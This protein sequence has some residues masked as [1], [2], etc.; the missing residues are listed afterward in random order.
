MDPDQENTLYLNQI[1]QKAADHI[2]GPGELGLVMARAGV[3]KTSF[4]ARLALSELACGREVLHIALGQNLEQVNAHYQYLYRKW[5]TLKEPTKEPTDVLDNFDNL[6]RHRAIQ[7]YSNKVLTTDQ[8]ENAIDVFSKHL[9]LHPNVIVVDG[10]DWSS[11]AEKD[12]QGLKNTAKQTGA[13]LWM[14]ARTDQDCT[15]SGSQCLK[16]TAGDAYS[17]VELALCM[18]PKGREVEVVVVR[19]DD[20]EVFRLD[21]DS[22]LPG[23]ADSEPAAIKA[24]PSE[25]VLHSG[26]AKGT[27]AEF[28]ACAEKWGLVEKNFSYKGREVVRSRGLVLLSAQELKQGAVS[29]AYLQAHL[30]REFSKDPDFKK[31]LQS[32]WH[33]VNQASE[34]FSVGVINSDGTVKGGTGWAVELA[35]HQKKQVHVYD[36]EKKSWYLWENKQWEKVEKPVISCNCFAGT[37]TRNLNSDGKKA[38]QGLFD[39]AFG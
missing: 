29:H 18:D 11:V 23:A 4:L 3:G 9:G 35:R 1:V 8:M 32:I 24:D 16:E 2:L 20:G 21:E 7:A 17:K 33:Q 25:F 37:G 6:V 39:R 5:V 31:V 27:E 36:Q 28:G 38:I 14:S 13:Y 30:H 15:E 10:L 26:G 19:P 22:M 12:I 34:V